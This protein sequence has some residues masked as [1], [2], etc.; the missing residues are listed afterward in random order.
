M[1]RPAPHRAGRRRRPAS[2]CA[3]R[4]SRSALR[5]RALRL[6][7]TAAAGPRRDITGRPAAT[8]S[9]LPE[10]AAMISGR[11]LIAGLTFGGRARVSAAAPLR[12]PPS[13]CDAAGGIA[14]SGTIARHSL[15]S[16]PSLARA[17]PGRC[18]TGP[19]FLRSCLRSPARPGADRRRCSAQDWPSPPTSNR[20]RSAARYRSRIRV[21]G[22]WHLRR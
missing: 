14:G 3:C 4:G 15:P 9:R 11:R 7:A 12:L 18:G 8:Q 5:T 1:R 10:R 16:G 21:G 6:M 17:E 2:V 22:C 19:L 13:G 20:R